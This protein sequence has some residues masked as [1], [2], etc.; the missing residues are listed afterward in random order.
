MPPSKKSVK[1]SIQ[2]L[3][4]SIHKSFGEE[5]LVDMSKITGAHPAISTGFS[6]VDDITGVGGFPK[7]RLIELYGPE[8]SGKSTLAIHTAALAQKEEN[9]FVLYVDYE[10][11]FDPRY[12][13]KLGLNVDDPNKFL[14]TQPPHLEEGMNI[15]S[16]FIRSGVATMVIVDSIA[17][18]PPQAEVEGDN[19]GAN[20]I[21]LH[22]LV[23]ANALKHI[24]HDIHYSDCVFIGINQVRTKIGVTWGSGETTPGGN[25]WKHYASMRMKLTKT[26]GVKGK[27][28]SEITGVKE[29]VVS[30]TKVR[31]EIS[32]NKLAVPFRQTE[33]LLRHGEGFDLTG[34]LVD[35][36]LA[37]NILTKTAQGW[38]FWGEK[39]KPG[40][41]QLRG[42]EL[43]SKHL[44]EN[45]EDLQRLQT[46]CAKTEY[47]SSG[48]VEF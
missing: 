48:T 36:A 7:G 46:Q 12:G 27:Y 11:A 39:D 24:I 35:E 32:K 2:D 14:L 22:S 44:K 4:S 29:D 30:A 31:I 21:G 41:L 19:V 40:F 1:P 5:A 20:R 18:A 8:H 13:R 38:I 26:A 17:A 37:K 28:T 10:H 15:A 16:E 43:F 45:P 9:G 42:A 34:G 6:N 47:P 33:L 25:A 3:I 23:W